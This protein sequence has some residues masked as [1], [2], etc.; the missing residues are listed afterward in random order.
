MR[1]F[2]DHVAH[3]HLHADQALSRINLAFLNDFSNKIVLWLDVANAGGRFFRMSRSI[4]RQAALDRL[5]TPEQLDQALRVTSSA[6]WAAMIGVA[7]LVVITT[8]WSV[9]GTAP[10]KVRG[11]GIL[12]NFGGI[13]DV[14][15]GADGRVAKFLVGPGDS[16]RV[17]TPVAILEQPDLLRDLDTAGAELREATAQYEQVRQFNE[18]DLRL[19]A[20]LT[21][22]K[23]ESF[24][25]THDFLTDRLKWLKERQEFEGD[26]Y[27]K[28]IIGRQRTID[29]RIE[30]NDTLERIAATGNTIKQLEL[31]E[32]TVRVAKEREV[33][34]LELQVNRLRR[35]VE[36]LQERLE[37]RSRV[38]SP[39]DGHVVELK[40][41]P[42][43]VVTALTPLFSMM[44]DSTNTSPAPDKPAD[45]RGLVAILYIPPEHGK[46]VQP[47]MEVQIAPSTVKREAFG[48][49]L[50][51]VKWV[52]EV[53]SSEEGM[54]RS[55]KNRKLVQDLAG[56][57]APFEV[58][59]ELLPDPAAPSGYRWSSSPGPAVMI[60]SG[61]LAEG[62]VTVRAVHIISLIVPALE[63]MLD[64]EPQPTHSAIPAPSAT[65][66]VAA[67]TATSPGSGASRP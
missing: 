43:E 46:K 4:F 11:Q 58:V 27:K 5:S 55:L 8:V 39:Y 41:N 23:T 61:T 42:G 18:R 31:E 66:V 17:G 49:M 14:V 36:S 63:P 13:L 56:H 3:G 47:G 16:V 51:R 65:P 33:L 22:Q 9:V 50:G 48:Y 35:Q 32:S 45:S 12:L 1:A 44:T 57:G 40:T 6:A 37:R 64:R 28:Q 25:Q 2:Q 59:V 54:M 21:A 10:V 60:N 24:R 7:V 52:A 29:T 38:L 19:Q 30:I 53:P 34:N 26:L 62:A 15:P 20:D 67:D